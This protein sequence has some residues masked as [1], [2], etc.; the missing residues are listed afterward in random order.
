MLQA[1]KTNT[2]PTLIQCNSGAAIALFFGFGTCHGKDKVALTEQHRDKYFSPCDRRDRPGS[3]TV[4]TR[5]AESRL[6]GG[7]YVVHHP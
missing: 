1:M 7:V 6:R 4:M 5:V 3:I 2:N